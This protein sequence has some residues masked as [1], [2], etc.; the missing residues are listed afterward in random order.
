MGAPLATPRQ[1]DPLDRR[2]VEALRREPKK[3]NAALGK[4]FGVAETTIAQRIAKLEETGALWIVG[5]VDVARLGLTQGVWL[6][7]RVRG[8]PIHQVAAELARVPEILTLS[9]QLSQDQ[10]FVSMVGRDLRDLTSLLETKVGAVKGIVALE[11]HL[12]LE[13]TLTLPPLLSPKG[14][15]PLPTVEE[16]IADIEHMDR[17]GQIDPLDRV[18]LAE[19]QNDGRITYRE[20]GRRHSVN[21]STVRSRAKRLETDGLLSFVAVG[22]PMSVGLGF[23]CTLYAKVAPNAGRAVAEKLSRL[24]DCWLVAR[25]LGRFEVVAAVAST[26]RDE[27]GATTYERISSL[28]GVESVEVHET[29]GRFKHS[30]GWS[31]RGSRPD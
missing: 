21:E 25:T 5:T 4:K 12:F 8:R 7:L 26:T 6:S 1:L 19:F 3:T 31:R 15:G 13:T 14:A 28:P 18:I 29:L 17:D 23:I 10:L 27:F 2:I 20:I 16:R 24:P 30:I 11:P 22:D 9:S